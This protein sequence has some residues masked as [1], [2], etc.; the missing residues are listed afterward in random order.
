MMQGKSG[1]GQFTRRSVLAGAASAALAIKAPAVHAQMREIRFLNDQTSVD[2]L[3]ALKTAAA[4]YEK[5]QGVRVTIDS[6]PSEDL[7]PRI[8]AGIRGGKPYDLTMV[9]FV[10]HM[11]SLAKEGQLTP[12]TDL[13][14][15]YKWGKRILFPVD[16]VHYYYPWAYTMCWLYYRKDIYEQQKLEPAKDWAH[17][18]DNCQRTSTDGQTKRYGHTTPIGSNVATNWMTFG[19][20]WAENAKLFNDDW[21]LAIAS[22]EGRAKMAAYLNFMSDLNKTMPPGATQFG[23]ASALQQFGAEQVTHAP[24]AGRMIEYLEQRAPQLADKYGMMPYPGSSAGGRAV[25]HGYKGFLVGKTPMSEEALKFL[26]WWSDE[27]YINFLHTAPLNFQPPRLDIYDD[28][29]WS[30]NPLIQ[31][32]AEAV[33]TMKGFLEDPDLIIRSIDTDGPAPDVRPAKVFESYVL[34]EMVQNRLL[35][36]MPADACVEQGIGKLVELIKT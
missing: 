3:R 9:I 31:K 12:V 13:V 33:R 1:K 19:F 29:R 26:A 20:L 6:V 16:G 22:P 11:L 28:P 34:P 18:L 8:L 27:Q 25:N 30:A 17:Y 35:K 36:D 5:Q 21:S 23:F 2:S 24:Y 10:A 15:K 4:E 14:G 32:H 7:Y